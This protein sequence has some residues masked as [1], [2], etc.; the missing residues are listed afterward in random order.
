MRIK[1]INLLLV[2]ILLKEMVKSFS[3]KKKS[4]L[5]YKKKLKNIKLIFIDQGNKML[6]KIHI[7]ECIF[8][9]LFYGILNIGNFHFSCIKK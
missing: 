7:V 5:T 3:L 9:V 6:L 2:E 8:F 4:S 1:Q